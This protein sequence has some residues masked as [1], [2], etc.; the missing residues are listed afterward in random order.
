MSS[1]SVESVVDP[2]HKMLSRNLRKP[3]VRPWSLVARSAVFYVLGTTAILLVTMVVL[4]DAV[5]RYGLANDNLYLTDKLRGVRADLA[6][7]RANQA[8]LFTDLLPTEAS[9]YFI[10]VLDRRTGKVLVESP[11]MGKQLLPP[12]FPVPPPDGHIPDQGIEYKTST[13][14]WFLLMS[15]LAEVDRT[16]PHPVIIQIAQ[17]RS[18]D[19]AFADFF[20]TLLLA[21]LLGGAGCSAAVAVLIAR[22]ALRPLRQMVA[23]MEKVQASHLQQ[24]LDRDQWPK[25]LDSLAGAFDEMLGRLK[26]S[27]ERLSAFSAD[28]AH[29]LRTPIQNLRGEAEVALTRTRTAAEYREVIELSIEEYEGLASMIDSLLFLARAENAETPMSRM[30]FKAGPEI[31]TILDF[32]DAAAREQNISVSRQGDTDL[33]ADAMLLRRAVNNLVSNSLQH[34]SAGGRILVTVQQVDDGVN[35]QVQDT[36]CGIAPKH[37]PRIF[38]RFYRADPA[39]ASDHGGV[40]LGLAIVKSIMDLHGGSVVAE[41][42]LGEGTTVTLKFVQKEQPIANEEAVGTIR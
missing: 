34:T 5:V 27:F 1:N 40:G 15:A 17:N 8:G 22:Q 6:T 32:Y 11:E 31:D 23:A 37:L 12:V 25:E 36:G 13:G 3:P 2:P 20:R 26:E 33:Y 42:K 18:D 35:I 4:Y 29:E 38:N 9:D 41:S 14:K 16:A 30:T 24:R 19:K 39:R 28:L 21:V 7:G 10:R